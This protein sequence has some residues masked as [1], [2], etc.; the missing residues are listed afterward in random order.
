MIDEERLP[1]RKL[2]VLRRNR[3]IRVHSIKP[4][5]RS[6]IQILTSRIIRLDIIRRLHAAAE[7]ADNRVVNLEIRCRR[8]GDIAR[9]RIETS[10]ESRLDLIERLIRLFTEII[11]DF[12]ASIVVVRSD[13][14]IK[15]AIGCAA[16]VGRHDG[17]E[18]HRLS[19]QRLER[20]AVLLERRVAR[21]R[22]IDDVHL[23]IVHSGRRARSILDHAVLNMMARQHTAL[24]DAALIH[25]A[26]LSGRVV[27]KRI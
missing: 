18:E 8:R 15:R 19:V 2:H 20:V 7:L 25:R 23:Q 22:R 24:I 13:F 21:N 3:H 11:D 10:E 9:S 1:E 5:G 27:I 14:E 16:L 17:V 4:S 6:R 26:A 12:C